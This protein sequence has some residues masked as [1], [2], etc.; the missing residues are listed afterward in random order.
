MA[1][2]TYAYVSSNTDGN[3]ITM[4]FTVDGNPVTI[5]IPHSLL[6]SFPSVVAMRN[7]LAP[8]LYKAAVG[9][10]MAP[11]PATTDVIGATSGTFT[12]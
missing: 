12:Q 11:D 10:G 6:V 2:H 7:Y 1:T 9:K 8:I 4:N 5:D 3:I